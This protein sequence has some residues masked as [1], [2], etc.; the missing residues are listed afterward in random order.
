M[1]SVDAEKEDKKAVEWNGVWPDSTRLKHD[2]DVNNYEELFKNWD[3]ERSWRSEDDILWA[4]GKYVDA[5]GDSESMPESS[6]ED[7][8]Q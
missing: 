7:D 1:D 2:V 4:E 3:Y 8:N 6:S 5:E